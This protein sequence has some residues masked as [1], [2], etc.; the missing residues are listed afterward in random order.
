VALTENIAEGVNWEEIEKGVYRSAPPALRKLWKELREALPGYGF[1]RSELMPIKSGPD[2]IAR[3]VGKYI[4]KHIGA[5]TE[6]Q[7]GVRLIS[8]SKGWIRNGCQ[9]A[10]NTKNASEWRRKLAL[11]AARHGCQEFYQISAKLGPGWAYKYA[12]DIVDMDQVIMEEKVNAKHEG[13]EINRSQYKDATITRAKE[14]KTIRERRLMERLSLHTK[15]PV[16]LEE[17]RKIEV[18]KQDVKRWTEEEKEESQYYGIT[19]NVTMSGEKLIYRT[20][21]RAGEEIF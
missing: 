8:Y 17:K 1:G 14:K 7:K 6:D 4:S 15:R 16:N 11:F 12:Q 21:S 13:R 20:G 10:W 2:A 18:A 5:R 19:G 3:Y 9:F